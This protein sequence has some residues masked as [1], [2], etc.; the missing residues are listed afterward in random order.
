MSNSKHTPGPWEYKRTSGFDFGSTEYWI[1]GICSHVR[2]EADACLIAAAPDLLDAL[3][4]SLDAF[5]DL[6]KT[7]GI[8]YITEI[9][10][11][12]AA[13]AK[14]EGLNKAKGET[15]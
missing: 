9:V 12:R 5:E 3:K 14:A 8:S 7:H 11:A 2:K 13:L 4:I 15:K 10:D 1:P 6:S